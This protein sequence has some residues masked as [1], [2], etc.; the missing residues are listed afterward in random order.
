L[1]AW[2]RMQKRQATA[3]DEGLAD[4]FADLGG[5]RTGSGSVRDIFS[6]FS[7]TSFFN[8]FR[9]STWCFAMYFST[10]WLASRRST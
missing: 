3:S 1:F 10:C 6:A 7:L 9:S 4:D 2:I 5:I 8:S